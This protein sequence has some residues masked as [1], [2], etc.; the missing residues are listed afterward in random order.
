MRAK[1]FV[2]NSGDV[3]RLRLTFVLM[4]AKAAG[5]RTIGITHS[6]PA[7]DLHEAD[8]IIHHLDELTSS[9][10]ISFSR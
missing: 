4:S 9:L 8:L 3:V 2:S 6:Y 10:L 1:V 5:L 7:T